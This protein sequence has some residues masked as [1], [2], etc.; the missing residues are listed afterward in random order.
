LNDGVVE[1][2]VVTES[3][4]TV[5]AYG[6]IGDDD[7]EQASASF[8]ETRESVQIL[9]GVFLWKSDSGMPSM[10]LNCSDKQYLSQAKGFSTSA[11]AAKLLRVCACYV[12]CSAMRC[13]M[14][15]VT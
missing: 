8:Y 4:I 9:H 14:R 15:D 3:V 7:A 5:K 6:F 2:N 13:V 10:G 12:T 11:L 1:G